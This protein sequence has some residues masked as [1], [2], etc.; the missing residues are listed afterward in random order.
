MRLCMVLPGPEAQQLA[1]YSGWRIGGWRHG[2]LAGGLFVL[3]GAVLVTALAW[4]HAVGEQ[5]P[6]V[7][8]AFDGTRPAV[9]ALVALAAWRIGKRSIT[10]GIAAALAIVAMAML[11]AGAPFPLIMLVAGLVGFLSPIPLALPSGRVEPDP[12]VPLLAEEA[13]DSQRPGAFRHAIAI[14]LPSAA[15][16]LASYGA[17][18]VLPLAPSRGREI[19]TLFTETTLLS[20]G[21]AYA[22]VPWA[23]DE[24]VARGWIA[25]AERFD[26]LAMGE[27]TPGPLI[28]VVTFLGF[29]AGYR[30]DL[31]ASAVAG[32]TGAGIATWFAFLPSFAMILA[33][34]PFVGKVRAVSRLGNALTAVGSVIVAAIVLLG[35]HLAE[36]AFL[37]G[38]QFDPIA[39]LVAIA[40]GVAL[41]VGRLSAPMVVALAA[42][43][44]V[45]RMLLA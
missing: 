21:G 34:A 16:W 29:M 8:A 18:G 9:V 13:Q 20:F 33:L 14:L 15:I 36:A 17:V 5:V 39:L 10:T 1:T 42:V 12:V 37:P 45:V 23:L 27:A 6:L 25:S 40:V 24:S 44:G 43:V 2:L 7:A 32:L 26:A 31:H 3:P 28:L 19:A 30:D 22:V 41:P 4:L 11:G 38:S 35:L